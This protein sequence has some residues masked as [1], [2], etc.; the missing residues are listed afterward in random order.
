MQG[1][2]SNGNRRSILAL[3]LVLMMGITSAMPVFADDGLPADSGNTAVDPEHV[4]AW[5]GWEITGKATYI[6]DGSRMRTCSICGETETETVQRL[7]AKSKWVTIDGRKYYLNA[8]GNVVRGWQKIKVSNAKKAQTKWCYFNDSGIFLKSISA[9]SKNKWITAD[10]KKF[11][12]TSAK[13][14]QTAGYHIIGGKL[15]FFNRDKSL[16][17]GKVTIDGRTYKTN[18]K[19]QLSGLPYYIY[20][21]R[22]FVLV[23]ISDQKLYM[24]KKG[25]QQMEVNVITGGNRKGASYTPTGKFRILTHSRNINLYWAGKRWPVNYWM[26]FKGSLFGF[27]DAKWRSD[28]EFDDPGTHINNGSHGCINMRKADIKKLYKLASNGTTVIIQN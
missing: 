26:A 2:N 13:K 1:R 7:I 28:D 17:I 4:H 6:A 27:H 3:M 23:D 11:Y 24:Y 16:Y 19:G 10:G 12:F 8:S 21:Y 20:K 9:A 25:V 18:S 14:P 5:S 15:Y 22:T